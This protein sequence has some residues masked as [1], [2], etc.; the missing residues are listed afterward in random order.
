MWTKFY[1]NILPLKRRCFKTR[2]WGRISSSCA[3]FESGPIIIHSERIMVGIHKFIIQRPLN[4]PVIVSVSERSFPAHSVPYYGQFGSVNMCGIAHWIS[5]IWLH[6][7]VNGHCICCPFSGPTV[8]WGSRPEPQL[9]SPFLVPDWP[10]LTT[11]TS[12]T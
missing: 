1:H 6:Q 3:P 8:P 12:S 5:G 10:D 2:S 11:W 4:I 9:P 7:N